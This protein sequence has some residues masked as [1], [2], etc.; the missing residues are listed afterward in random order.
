MERYN[1]ETFQIADLIRR[2]LLQLQLT[3]LAELERQTGYVAATLDQFL[4]LRRKLSKAS[5]RGY[6][7]AGKR[8]RRDASYLLMDLRHQ[9]ET[10]TRIVSEEP[11][12][13]PPLRDV[14]QDLE[15]VCEEFGD[16]KYD[17]T[18]GALSVFTSDIELEDVFLGPFEIRLYL[19]ELRDL[20]LRQP[21]SVIALDPHPPSSND[22][23]THPHVSDNSLC[24]G[25]ATTTIKRAFESGRVCDALLLIQSVLTH[26]N[27]Q[28]P[29]VSLEHWEGESCNDCGYMMDEDGHYFCEGCEQS[30]C[31]DCI[32][33]CRC[34][35]LS[36]CRGCLKH[37]EF[38]DERICADCLKSCDMCGNPCC[39]SCLVDGLCP[40]CHESKEL[41]DEDEE[42]TPQTIT[43]D[44]LNTH[45]A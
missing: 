23:V 28:S 24:A 26:Y 12:P 15:Q 13:I 30:F 37:C 43:E 25:E 6:V 29:Y 31:C 17:A 34:C 2:Q 1:R 32:S 21:F 20:S 3:Q 38:C 35:D 36:M 39:T 4:S 7:N 33:A 41:D 5:H 40:D 18:D 8:L 14:L 22:A 44:H 27:P 19:G 16:W 42:E 10:A 11:S 45:A 9:V